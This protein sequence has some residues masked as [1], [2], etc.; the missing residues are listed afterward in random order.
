MRDAASILLKSVLEGHE[1]TMKDEAETISQSSNAKASHASN[2]S[3]KI[4]FTIDHTIVPKT[5]TSSSLPSSSSSS[6]AP[7]F[8]LALCSYTLCEIP[9]VPAA[10]S[11]AVMIWEKLRPDGIA[12]FIEPGTPDGFNALRS[13][14]SMLL[15]CCPPSSNLEKEGEEKKWDPS[16]VVEEE[17][18]VIAPC[19]H[20]GTCPMVRHRKNNVAD[21]KDM[22]HNHESDDDDDEDDE[23]DEDSFGFDDDVDDD[24]E[25]DI[26]DEN[27]NDDDLED[28]D[29]DSKDDEIEVD[30]HKDDTNHPSKPHAFDT[31]FCSFVHGMPGKEHGNQGEK[32]SY[33]VVQKRI[34]GKT[35]FHDMNV[36]Y[37]PFHDTS[38]VDL[39]KESLQ[40]N[41]VVSSYKENLLPKNHKKHHVRSNENKSSSRSHVLLEKAMNLE[42]KFIDSNMDKLG[43]EFVR[44]EHLSQWGRIVRAPIK[45]KGHVILD[46]CSSSSSSSKSSST[47]QQETQK[48]GRIHR[49]MVTKSQSSKSAPGMYSSSRKARWGGFWPHVS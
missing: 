44:G 38:L 6:P 24:L 28:W 27:D 15:D 26:H 33:L 5:K 13:V 34:R 3:S 40:H 23:D 35:T 47:S 25:E 16:F 11:M 17:C 37:N 43:L 22:F 2:P 7:S 48:E 32:F 46:Y 41:D 21:S 30:N 4:R 9:S 12:I 39:L 29:D 18:H 42:E 8:D 14:R 49:L 10:L 36:E 31:A 20:N 1:E 45:K 19:T